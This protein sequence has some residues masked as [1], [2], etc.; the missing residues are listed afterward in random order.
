[1]TLS[2]IV[3]EKR[4][5]AA[6]AQAVGDDTGLDGIAEVAVDILL[7]GVRVGLGGLRKERID[8]LVGVEI[9]L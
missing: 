5:M 9:R 3:I 2:E 6:N 4:N 8:G 7:P 1:M